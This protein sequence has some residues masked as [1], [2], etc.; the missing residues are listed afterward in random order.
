MKANRS[1]L[2]KICV[3]CHKE[4]FVNRDI[5]REHK[6]KKCCLN[7]I[8]RYIRKPQPAYGHLGMSEMYVASVQEN[9][10]AL[11]YIPEQFHN[12]KLY[13]TAVQQNGLALQ[14]VPKGRRT[15]DICMAAMAENP[16]TSTNIPSHL[17]KEVRTLRS[18]QR[19][20]L[21]ASQKRVL[22]H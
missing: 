22:P 12:Q 6:S 16:M 5:P 11:Q 15:L 17:I 21:L 1:R 18:Q 4:A 9:G 3:M 20:S 13:L 10:L 2:P 19:Q 8:Q 7:A 14:Y